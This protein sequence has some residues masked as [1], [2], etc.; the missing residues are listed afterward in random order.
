[1]GT[2]DAKRDKKAAKA[3]AKIEKARAKAEADIAEAKYSAESGLPGG[4]HLP[5]GIGIS[6]QKRGSVHDLVVS[7]LKDEQVRRIVPHLNKEIL[8]AVE[9]D[10]SAFRAGVMRFVREGLFQTVI[11]VAAGLIVGILLIELRLR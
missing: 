4:T 1:M 5:D 2:D 8:I 10:R 6:I 7:G 3:Q 9:A 11:K